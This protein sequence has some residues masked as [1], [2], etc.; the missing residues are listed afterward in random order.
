MMFFETSAKTGH[1]IEEVFF[2][3]SKLIAKKISEDFYDLSNEVI[4]Y[5][6]NN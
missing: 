2:E 3:S 5:F 4:I 1:N 6:Y